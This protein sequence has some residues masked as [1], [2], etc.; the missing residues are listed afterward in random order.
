MRSNYQLWFAMGLLC[1]YTFI[2]KEIAYA[3]EADKDVALIYITSNQQPNEDVFALQEMLQTSTSV[4]VVFIEDVN[5]RNLQQYKRIVILSSYQTKIPQNALSSINQ[6]QGPVLLIGE[7]A[8]Q[9]ENFSTWHEGPTVEL[10]AIGEESLSNPVRWKSIQPSADWEIVKSA[11]S[12]NQSY[13]FIVTKDNW[14]FIGDFINKD[15]LLYQWPA[16]IGELLHLSKPQI[17]PAYIVLTDINMKT[18]VQQLE[19]VVME[20]SEKRIPIALEITPILQDEFEKETY[21]LHDNKKLLSYLQKL[22]KEGYPFVLSS[23][24][25]SQTEKNLDY[26][27]LRKIYPTITSGGDSPL[28]KGSIQQGSQQ[29]Y[30]SQIDSRTIYP[31]TVGTIANTDNNPLYPVKQKIKLLLKVPSS[32]IGIQYPAYF[33]A[34]YVEELAVYL[35]EHPQIE[36]L[37]LRQT[38]QQVTSKNISI[39]Q[40]ENGEQTIQLAFT[41]IERLK[42]LFEERPVELILWAVCYIIFY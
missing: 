8:L 18:E 26:L 33:N 15:L 25:A 28:F 34:S 7:N 41:K 42:I 6:F 5:E 1:F 14:S 37:N 21:Y 9:F 11:T 36:L 2:N 32:I 17:H 24:T 12:L 19:D 3:G 31:V 4:D 22:Q 27:V 39:K 30:L 38:K 10:R 16:M 20:F 23:S 35:S 40:H 29:L 13:P